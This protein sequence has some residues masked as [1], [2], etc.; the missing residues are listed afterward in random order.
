MLTSDYSDQVWDLMSTKL[1]Q[2]VVCVVAISTVLS[3][4]SF[5]TGL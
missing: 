5:I 3:L 4:K 2:F 1:K